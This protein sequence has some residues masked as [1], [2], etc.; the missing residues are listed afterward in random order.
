MEELCNNFM[1]V[2]ELWGYTS[3]GSTVMDQAQRCSDSSL[4]HVL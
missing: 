3:F 1:N 2:L 4:C